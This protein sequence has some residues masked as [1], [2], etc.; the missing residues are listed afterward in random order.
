MTKRK[1]KAPPPPIASDDQDARH[2]LANALLQKFCETINAAELACSAETDAA[3]MALICAID[4]LL[5]AVPCAGCAQ[6]LAENLRR[7]FERMLKP[8]LREPTLHENHAEL[9]H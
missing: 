6:E 4:Q 2:Q 7:N 9:L 1:P 3:L 5:A 8:H